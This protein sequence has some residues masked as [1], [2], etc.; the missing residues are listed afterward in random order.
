MYVA[1]ANNSKSQLLSTVVFVCRYIWV[2]KGA[3]ELSKGM[4][5]FSFFMTL[6]R[7]DA[8][9]V[10]ALTSSP[11]GRGLIFTRNPTLTKR[12]IEDNLREYLGV[13]TVVWL[14]KGTV[15]DVDT[16]G[17]ID[18]LLAFVRPGEVSKR[19]IAVNPCRNATKRD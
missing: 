6:A 9:A 12:E 4:T 2:P 19:A 5:K 1:R 10:W 16:D 11:N 17:H 3:L 14:G 15:G 8:S 7:S 13:D 18:N